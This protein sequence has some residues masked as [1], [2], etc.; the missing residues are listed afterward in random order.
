MVKSYQGVRRAPEKEVQHIRVA[1]YMTINLTTFHP[2]DPI[3]VV[4]KTFI[5]KKISGA[6]VLDSDGKLVGIISEG[7]CLKEIVKGKYNNSPQNNGVV[8]DLMV[9]EVHTIGPDVSVFDAASMFL[10]N[11]VRRFPVMQNGKLLG[12]VSQRDVLT[13]ISELK[14]E[15]W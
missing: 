3:G 6:P 5:S 1:D 10:A 7:D 11:R 15:T 14:N 9:R 4:V 8:A 2:D 12:Q 13:A